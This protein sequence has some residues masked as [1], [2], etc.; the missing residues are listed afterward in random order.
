MKPRPRS[1]DPF[2]T[3]YTQR[4][5]TLT[6]ATDLFRQPAVERAPIPT[7]PRSVLEQRYPHIVR[8]LTLM[9][10]HPEMN[11]YFDS[12]WLQDGNREGFHPEAMS[13]LMLLAHMHQMLVPTRPKATMAKIYSPANEQ[14]SRPSRYD[15]FWGGP[16]KKIK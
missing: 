7:D 15:A 11:A 16:P 9:W 14:P 13:E 8:A 4:P 2:A 10:G 3:L 12:L 5:A 6:P 1:Y